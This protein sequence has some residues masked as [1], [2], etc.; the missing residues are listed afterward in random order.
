[1]VN[2]GLKSGIQRCKAR[3]LPGGDLPVGLQGERIFA[4]KA[5]LLNFD[6]VWTLRSRFGSS[7]S[8]FIRMSGRQYLPWG[9]KK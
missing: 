5:A 9:I 2:N 4:T 6:Q 8:W 7:D 1:M 3:Y